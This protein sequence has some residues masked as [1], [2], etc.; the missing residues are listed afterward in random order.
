MFSDLDLVAT[1]CLLTSSTPL[2]GGSSR[3][4]ALQLLSKARL[5]TG[6]RGDGLGE[7]RL[8]M[9]FSSGSVAVGIKGGR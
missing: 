9:G 1:D 3:L 8:L 6:L 4:R 5:C 7:I 2:E